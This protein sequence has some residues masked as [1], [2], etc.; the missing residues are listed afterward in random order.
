M[1][2]KIISTLTGV[3][4]RCAEEFVDFIK[5]RTNNGKS[6]MIAIS[7]G[8]TPKLLFQILFANYSKSVNWSLVHFF[9]VD[10]RCV[11]PDDPESNYGEANNILLKNVNIP[12]DNIHRLKG[13]ANPEKEVL[14]Y[15]EELRKFLRSKNGYPVFD[16]VLLGMGDDGHTA[17]IFPGNLSLIDSDRLCDVAIHPV[18]G[19]KRLTLT[20]KVINNSDEI[21]FLITG[22]KKAQVIHDIF[23]KKGNWMHYPA[24]FIAPASGNMFWFL[25]YDASALIKE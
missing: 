6:V 17:S 3:A 4:E 25:D 2:I 21:W 23:T 10:E 13:E 11:S 20:G 22:N 24:S 16:L 12:L 19:Q 8:N 9:W 1:N 15:A 5:L 7:G 18:T 14:R